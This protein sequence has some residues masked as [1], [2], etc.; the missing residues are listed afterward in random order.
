MMKLYL[1]A[2]A[3]LLGLGVGAPTTQAAITGGTVSGGGT[4]SQIAP[5]SDVGNDNQNTNGVLFAFDEQQNVT[6]SGDLTVNIIPTGG[7]TLIP[8]GTVVSSHYVFFDP[9]AGSIE[10][11]VDFSDDILGVVEVDGDLDASAAE[12][13][14][15]GTTYASPSLLGLESGDTVEITGPR[16]IRF[17]VTAGSP[18]DYVRVITVP[19]PASLALLVPA[20]LMLVR[21][22]RAG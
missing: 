20:G 21:R 4:F 8:T 2:A 9:I 6:L 18:G 13:G 5:P 1:V 7:S 12:L 19:E 22:R 14:A 3:L 16:Q 11:T 17:D 10:G 15:P